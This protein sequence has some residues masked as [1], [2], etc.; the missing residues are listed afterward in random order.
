M[1]LGTEQHWLYAA[2]DTETKLLLGIRLSERRTDLAAEFL[3]Q[4][5]EKHDLLA[6]TFLVDGILDHAGAM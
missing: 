5:A 1:K 6:A 3:G 2:I 4:L